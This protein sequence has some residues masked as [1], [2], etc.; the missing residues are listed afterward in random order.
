MKKVFL[1]IISVLSIG[2]FLLAANVWNQTKGDRIQSGIAGEVIRFHVRANSETARDQEVKMQV[3]DA[4]VS[5]L[6]P[7]LEEAEDVEEAAFLLSEKLSDIRGVAE[8]VLQQEKCIYEVNVSLK[9]ESFP[10]K[11]YGDCTF[12]AGTYSAVVI[13]LGS[14]QGHNWWC[15]LYPGLCFVDETYAVVSEEKKE[16]LEYVLSEEEYDWVTNPENQ[17]ITF[18]WKWLR[19][20][21]DVFLEF[22]T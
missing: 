4:V 11:T 8:K 18:R 5:Y 14:G 13:E 16:E 17:R 1:F 6:Q 19:A 7:V 12:P 21:M 15:M 3:K 10:Q 9:K 22:P 20:L 2:C